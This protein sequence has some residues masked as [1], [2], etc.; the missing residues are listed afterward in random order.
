M[1]QDQLD[2]ETITIELAQ[3]I[4]PIMESREWLELCSQM[5]LHINKLIKNTES[6]EFMK[7]VSKDPVV[8][9]DNLA[10]RRGIRH[11]VEYP[12]QLRRAAER[13]IAKGAER[14]DAEEAK[15]RPTNS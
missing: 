12:G 15:T 11:V 10:F 1:S 7:E 14:G 9:A 4:I 3:K 8:F 13:L 2:K 5:E 6:R